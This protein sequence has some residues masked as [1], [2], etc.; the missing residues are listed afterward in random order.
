[1]NMLPFKYRYTDREIQQLLKSLTILVDTREQQNQHLI[2]YFDSKKILYEIMKLEV[3]D[4]SVMLPNCPELGISRD[5]YFPISIERKNSVDELVQTIK[6]RTRFE[7]ELIRSQK[8]NFL[9][10]VEDNKGYESIL[11]GNYLSQYEPKA[12][13]GSLKTFEA[14]FGFSTVFI[15]KQY[16]GNYIYHHSYYYV[17]NYLKGI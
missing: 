2:D 6:E 10:L 5:M 9:L 16:A 7:N 17:R 8:L 12:L 11:Y 15:S 13:L 14:R 3:G 1:M 4:Y